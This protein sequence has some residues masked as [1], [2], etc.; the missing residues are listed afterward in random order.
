MNTETEGIILK[1]I[2]TINGRRMVLLFSKKYGKI[3]AG[4]GISE[5]GKNRSALAMRPF[6]HGRYDIYK[7]AGTYHINGA[8]ALKAYY[9]IGEDVEK[10]MCASYILEFT[11]KLLPE[12]LPSAEIFKLL[13]DFLDL[14]ETRNKKHMTVVIAFQL[15][16]I[17]S[18]GLVP[19]IHACIRCG[20]NEGIAFFGVK[21][22][23]VLCGNCRNIIDS[24]SNV[25]LIYNIDFDIITT[26]TYFF[27][28]NLK[29]MENIALNEKILA[30]LR[31]IIKDYTAY[32]LG[33]KELKSEGFL[34]D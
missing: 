20:V 13:L 11:E 34:K 19:E 17:Q 16:A 6:T 32:H 1:Q 7:S 3:S 8:E 30:K 18:M 9:K 26:L 33:I 31:V 21:E 27:G 12:G 15:K 28:N 2:K 10:Y 14:I 22:G 4:T 29:S 24:D 23:G 5:R 25:K